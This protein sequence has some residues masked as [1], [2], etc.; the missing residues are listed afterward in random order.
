MITTTLVHFSQWLGASWLSS[1]VA[2]HF[3]VVPAL[4]TVHI[5]SVAVVLLGVLLINL[6]VVG[7]VE[8]GQTVQAVLDRF[9][10]PVGIAILV[11]AVTGLLL[12]A[13][14][15][16][17]AIFRT[18]FWV[19]LALILTAGLL[20]WS[21]RQALAVS[22]SQGVATTTLRK[23]IALLALLL[24]LAVIVAGRWIAYVD[25]WPGAPA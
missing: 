2:G 6:R 13:G 20:T 9:L 8:R 5:L 17:R 4:Q 24:W 10:R 7:L 15:P 21:H 1:A 3:W 18:I 23:G 22:G 16:T 11:L 25:A 19:K 14:E 12:I